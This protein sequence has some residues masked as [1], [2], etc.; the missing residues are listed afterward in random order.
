MDPISAALLS[1]QATYVALLTTLPVDSSGEG[2]VEAAL[3][4]VSCVAWVATTQDGGQVI[5]NNAAIEFTEVSAAL[6]VVGFGIFDSF[7]GGGLIAVGA[8]VD[9]LGAV[10]VNLRAGEGPRILPYQLSILT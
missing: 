4:R 6:A 8:F 7:S 10:A 5:T 2:L 1:G 3:A 9:D